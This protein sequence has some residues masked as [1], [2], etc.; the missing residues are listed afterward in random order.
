MD[1]WKEKE[2]RKKKRRN[3]NDIK[4]HITKKDEQLE[5]FMNMLKN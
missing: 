2:R 5:N 3:E 1:G 4:T